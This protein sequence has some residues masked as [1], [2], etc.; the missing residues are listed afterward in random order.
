MYLDHTVETQET[1]IGIIYS[2]ISLSDH[3]TKTPIGSSVS[4]IAIGGSYRIK[5]PPISLTSRVFA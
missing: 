5:Q 4:Q 3:L 1:W 2:G